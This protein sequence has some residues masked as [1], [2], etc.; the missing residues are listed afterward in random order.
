MDIKKI[1]SEVKKWVETYYGKE[2]WY[3]SDFFLD[4]KG[5]EY[6]KEEIKLDREITKDMT[7]DEI[8]DHIEESLGKNITMSMWQQ[9]MLR[10][11]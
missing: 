9:E 11:Y 4:E 8:I 2:G 5:F 1:Y 7:D 3:Y 6:F 10:G